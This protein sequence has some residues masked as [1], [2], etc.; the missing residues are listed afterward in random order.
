MF[1]CLS[2]GPYNFCMG[3]RGSETCERDCRR[4]NN[5]F[6]TANSDRQQQTATT[7]AATGHNALEIG[8][9][10][11]AWTCKRDKSCL[12]LHFFQRMYPACPQIL[13]QEDCLSAFWA[14]RLKNID[15]GWDPPPPCPPTHTYTLPSTDTCAQAGVPSV[16]SHCI[17]CNHDF[18]CPPPFAMFALLVWD[19]EI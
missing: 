3:M 13:I 8:G 4:S 10:Y 17:D 19:R 12:N 5:A 18:L 7:Q 2:G 15:C 11:P 1:R 16:L 6:T 14:S 9:M